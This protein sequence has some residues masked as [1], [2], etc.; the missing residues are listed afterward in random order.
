MHKKSLRRCLDHAL[1]TYNLYDYQCVTAQRTTDVSFKVDRDIYYLL[2][3]RR[4]FKLGTTAWPYLVLLSY[5]VL[6]ELQNFN[7]GEAHHH[8]KMAGFGA[9]YLIWF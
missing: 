4:D 6:S 1:Y 8:T 3:E 2:G 9:R 7:V 5:A